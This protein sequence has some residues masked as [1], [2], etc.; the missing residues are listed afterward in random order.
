MNEMLKYLGLGLRS[1]YERVLHMPMSWR[2]IDAI[3]SLEEREEAARGAARD[4]RTDAA[5]HNAHSA[6]KNS[7]R[8]PF[9]RSR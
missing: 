4:G 1:Q 9:N 8:P 5:M 3:A 7:K 2:M 6:D